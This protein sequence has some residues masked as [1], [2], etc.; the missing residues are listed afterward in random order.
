MVNALSLF[1]YSCIFFPIDRELGKLG[2]REEKY[3]RK[4]KGDLGGLPTKEKSEEFTQQD[5]LGDTKTNVESPT[6]ATTENI[7]DSTVKVDKLEVQSSTEKKIEDA[8]KRS[9]TFEQT[10]IN[11]NSTPEP[12]TEDNVKEATLKGEPASK[13]K[14]RENTFKVEL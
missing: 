5:K 6:K 7:V 3:A 4:K 10:T 14:T 12:V 2:K 9:E 1:L 11:D 13:V 8:T